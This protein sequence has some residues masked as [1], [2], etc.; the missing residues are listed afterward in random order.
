MSDKQKDSPNINKNVHPPIVAMVFIIIG[1]L[2]GRL[3]PIL[4][5]MPPLLRTSGWV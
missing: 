5:G 1:L 3:V 4:A 2:M